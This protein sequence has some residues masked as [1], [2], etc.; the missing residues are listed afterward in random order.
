MERM[1]DKQESIYFITG[2]SKEEV[3]SSTFVEHLLKKGYEVLFLTEA[4][5]E[6][7]FV[8][9]ARIQGEE[10]RERRQGGIQT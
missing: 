9:P 8:L 5:N 6:Y 4:I 2:S 10:V 3:S 1:K 7:A